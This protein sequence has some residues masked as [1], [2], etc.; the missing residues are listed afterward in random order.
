MQLTRRGAAPA[1]SLSWLS[2]DSLPMYRS[3]RG[4][5]RLLRSACPAHVPFPI[6]GTTRQA[7]VEGKPSIHLWTRTNELDVARVYLVPLV[8]VPA[9]IRRIVSEIS[10][11]GESRNRVWKGSRGGTSRWADRR[12]NGTRLSAVDGNDRTIDRNLFAKREGN[13]SVIRKS[14]TVCL[15]GQHPAALFFF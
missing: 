4:K 6:E 1:G 15:A 12:N 8:S 5:F 9:T 3:A 7:K 13:R 2:P 11:N 10:R 14:G